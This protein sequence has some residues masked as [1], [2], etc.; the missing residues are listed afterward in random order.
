MACRFCADPTRKLVNAH[1]IPEAF[2]RRASASG[3]PNLLSSDETQHRRRAPIGIYDQ[4]ILCEVCEPVFGPWDTYAIELLTDRPKNGDEKR[5]GDEIV[6]MR[7]H[8][9]AVTC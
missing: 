5:H 3:T 2:F 9:T 1:I 8:H 4:E 7:S 6:P